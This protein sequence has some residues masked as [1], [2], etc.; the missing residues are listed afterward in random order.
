MQML[1]N[2]FGSMVRQVEPCHA[3]EDLLDQDLQTHTETT[4]YR[5]K[6]KKIMK[7]YPTTDTHQMLVLVNM[8]R[9]RE[10][11]GALRLD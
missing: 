7:C 6:L 5:R 4:N 11:S 8:L 10:Y 9:G 1:V 3:A 2:V